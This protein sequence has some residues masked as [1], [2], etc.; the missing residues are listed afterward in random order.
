MCAVGSGGGSEEQMVPGAR[1]IEGRDRV[2]VGAL[3]RVELTHDL[4]LDLVG[5]VAVGEGV[6]ERTGDA[7]D[8]GRIGRTTVEL[9]DVL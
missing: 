5:K 7:L 9:I 4:L 8:R 1:Q 2:R 3:E 6:E